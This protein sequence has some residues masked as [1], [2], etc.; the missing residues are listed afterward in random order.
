MPRHTVPLPS[1]CGVSESVALGLPRKHH[2]LNQQDRISCGPRTC[3]Q[4]NGQ[5]VPWGLP[6]RQ[7]ASSSTLPYPEE[8]TS[9]STRGGSETFFSGNVRRGHSMY[10]PTS[11]STRPQPP[12]KARAAASCGAGRSLS[13]CVVLQGLPDQ[14]VLTQTRISLNSPR[15]SDSKPLPTPAAP[16]V[17][18]AEADP[19]SRSVWSQTPPS[20]VPLPS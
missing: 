16:G 11:A 14:A 2:S 15:Q 3:L 4:G 13:H 8:S 5:T 6:Q 19:S 10:L 17:C 7:H 9:I 12:E 18:P 20:A 1:P